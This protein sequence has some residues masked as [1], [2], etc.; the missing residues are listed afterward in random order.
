[1]E[2]EEYELELDFTNDDI[3]NAKTATHKYKHRGGYSPICDDCDNCDC[4]PYDTMIIGHEYVILTYHY[5]CDD[6]TSVR[7]NEPLPSEQLLNKCNEI[8]SV[9]CNCR[10][11]QN[12]LTFDHCHLNFLIVCN[13]CKNE[14]NLTKKVAYV[15]SLRELFVCPLCNHERKIKF[16]VDKNGRKI[17]VPCYDSQMDDVTHRHMYSTLE[18]RVYRKNFINGCESVNKLRNQYNS[19]I[20]CI[21]YQMKGCCNVPNCTFKHKTYADVVSNKN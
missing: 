5:K 9:N 20:Q 3:I 18:E 8:R 21:N 14:H 19:N 10:E 7:H 15:D 12:N 13:K 4:I 1:M 2:F 16:Q 6:C 17:K 11:P